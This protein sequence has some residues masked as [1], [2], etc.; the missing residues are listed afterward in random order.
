M[1]YSESL[2]YLPSDITTI[3]EEVTEGLVACGSGH[4]KATLLSGRQVEVWQDIAKQTGKAR[5]VAFSRA[6]RQ[7][8]ERIHAALPVGP[9]PHA[10]NHPRRSEPFAQPKGGSEPSVPA[11]PTQPTPA[12][13]A[14][15]VG[16]ADQSEQPEALAPP[17]PPLQTLV[18]PKSASHYMQPLR[19]T[20]ERGEVSP[21]PTSGALDDLSLRHIDVQKDEARFASHPWMGVAGQ[22]LA[23]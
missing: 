7:E 22:Q 1:A 2:Q 20:P 5:Q 11:E 12:T 19:P 15:P 9:V 8:L 17:A 4:D 21:Q 6:L 14:M 18:A 23:S 13:P 16:R 3:S 10:V